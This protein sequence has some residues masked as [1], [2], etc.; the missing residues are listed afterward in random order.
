MA[1]ARFWKRWLRL[2]GGWLRRRI[3]SVSFQPIV[4]RQSRLR[5]LPPNDT[6]LVPCAAAADHGGGKRRSGIKPLSERFY[7]YAE[8]RGVYRVLR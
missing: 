5:V 4:S 1:N 6:T 2:G 8:E 7:T 3:T